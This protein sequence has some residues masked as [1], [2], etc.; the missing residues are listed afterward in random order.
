MFVRLL[1]AGGLKAGMVA[2]IKEGFYLIG[3]NEECQIRP[4][5]T[6]VS[7]RHCLL[8]HQGK[9]FRAF[10]LDEDSPTLV[11]HKPLPP[12]TWVLLNHGDML[13]VGNIP[14]LVT[15]TA[16]DP[17]LPVGKPA[18]QT[19]QRS[20]RPKS[21]V[22]KEPLA[23]A[24]AS[25]E[26]F[27]KKDTAEIEIDDIQ[28]AEGAESTAEGASTDAD[29]SGR[30]KRSDKAKQK[31]EKKRT[32]PKANEAQ[33]KPKKPP[34]ATMRSFDPLGLRFRKLLAVVTVIAV[35]GVG[36]YGAYRFFSDSTP[37]VRVLQDID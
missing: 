27:A 14:F 13:Q 8:Q 1:L 15:I 35:L 31:R 3:R 22:A 10:A 21:S 34:S 28:A 23:P 32:D 26:E 4:E 19:N 6:S 9:Y 12:K 11:N 16:Q 29:R 17:S 20:T 30:W 24:K 36:A 37:N 18:S 2:E 7:D 5:S 33:S 25:P